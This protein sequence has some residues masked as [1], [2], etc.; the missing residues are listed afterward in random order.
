MDKKNKNRRRGKRAVHFRGKTLDEIRALG[1]QQ[2]YELFNARIRRRLSANGGNKRSARSYG[3]KY[4]KLKKRI[5]KSIKA[6]LPGEK[7]AA[8]KTHLRDAIIVPDMV[9]GNVSVYN[10]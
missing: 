10:G 9:G 7:P 6:V 3:F 4:T 2:Q 8:V 5:V 1:P